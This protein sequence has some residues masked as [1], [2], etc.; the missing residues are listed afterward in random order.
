MQPWHNP[1]A[2]LNLLAAFPDSTAF[3]PGYWLI[4]QLNRVEPS[5][6]ATIFE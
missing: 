2:G 6:T 4:R 1:G 5:R 3:H